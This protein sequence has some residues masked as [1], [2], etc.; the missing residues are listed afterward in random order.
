MLGA[1]EKILFVCDANDRSGFGHAARCLKVARSVLARKPESEA[2]FQ[3]EFSEGARKALIAMLPDIAFISADDNF[4]AD[5]ALIDRMSDFDDI[6]ACDSVLVARIARRC[7]KTVYLTSGVSVPLLPDG[8][9][10][11]G[12]QPG[13]PTARPPNLYWGIEYAPVSSDLLRHTIAPRC[14]DS[15]LIAF[16]GAPDDRA[17]FQGVRAFALIP[18]IIRI[19]VLLSPVNDRPIGNLPFRPDQEVSYC[20]GLPSI[21]PL[22]AQSGVV[23]A[24][25]GNL[26]YE[27]L[28]IGA[29]L[30]FLGTKKFQSDLACAFAKMNIA[31]TAG[32]LC[33]SSFSA[34]AEACREALERADELSRNA[35]ALIDGNGI[36]RIADFLLSSARNE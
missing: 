36:D 15:A 21:G 16:G 10:C 32:L 19:N 13:G 2:I 11:L 4:F 27:A 30:C 12:Y 5:V 9:V 8:V 34:I 22:L 18:E 23:L 31:T 6:E 3:G 20:R 29:P 33:D 24:S 26:G 14:R 17:L 1:V 25:F 35:Q 7:G 28:A